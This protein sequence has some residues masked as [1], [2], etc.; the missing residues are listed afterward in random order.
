MLN[1]EPKFCDELT[2]QV[3]QKWTPIILAY[4]LPDAQH[5]KELCRRA[6]KHAPSEFRN[7]LEILMHERNGVHRQIQ[8]IRYVSSFKDANLTQTLLSQLKD[9][10]LTTESV[11]ALLEELLQHGSQE[12]KKFAESLVTSILFNSSKEV[13]AKAVNAACA[14]MLHTEDAGWPI[15]WPVI[16]QD[17]EF[18]QQVLE[19]VSYLSK[20]EGRVEHRL[21][22]DHLAD[23]YIFLTKYYPDQKSEEQ[24]STEGGGIISSQDRL[25]R[26]RDSIK[27]WRNHIP[28]R[29]Q[30]RGTKEACNALKKIIYELPELKDD[31]QWRLLE[32]EA[33][34]RRTAWQPLT[35]ED[36]LKLVIGRE[37]SNSDL[38][39]Q[40]ETIDRRTKK[41]EDD[42]KTENIVNNISNSNINAPVGNV[43][44]THSH[45]T[46]SSSDT[47]SSANRKKGINWELLLTIIGIMASIMVSGAFNKEFRQFFNQMFSPQVEQESTPSV[48]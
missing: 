16:Q 44:E 39:N 30:E 4:P 8:I 15:V 26:P 45:V 18:G 19:S 23:L 12:A 41:M 31:L 28:K 46:T 25:I 42:P 36:F 37:P 33:L 34:T 47:G 11:K 38:S 21:N 27:M 10:N 3:W 14:L 43:G 20:F 29:I 13:R 5:H 40:L 9:V 2:A 48:D 35:P 1:A 6:Y 17:P 24:V 7:V 32:T 22:E